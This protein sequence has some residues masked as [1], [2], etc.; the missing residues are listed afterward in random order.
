MNKQTLKN[1][2]E[3]VQKELETEYMVQIANR[4]Q[5]VPDEQLCP[6]RHQ[7]LRAYELVQ[8]EDVKVVVLGLDPHINEEACGLSFS[9]QTGKVPPP[10]RVIFSTFLKCGLSTARRTDGNLQD[11][12][13]QGVLLLNTVLTT[14]RGKTLAHGAWGWQQFTGATLKYLAQSNQPI[15][16]LIWGNDAKASCAQYI[17]PFVNSN[18]LILENCHPVAEV[19]GRVKFS[20]SKCFLQTNEFLQAHNLKPI[21]WDGSSQTTV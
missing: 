3:I 10:L 15:V 11:W 7:I 16:F 5:N 2:P 8:A 20:D 13:E 6:P 9:C 17:K 1:W 21:L 18:K 4:L 12:A 19:Y 14:T